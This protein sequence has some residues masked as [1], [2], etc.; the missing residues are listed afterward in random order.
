MAEGGLDLDMDPLGEGAEDINH[1]LT[2]DDIDELSPQEKETKENWWGRTKERLRRLGI[3]KNR[4]YELLTNPSESREIRGE[5]LIEE[6]QLIDLSKK[7]EDKLKIGKRKISTAAKRIRKFYPFWDPKLSS[8]LFTVDDFNITEVKLKGKKTIY[9]LYEDG[10]WSGK[11]PDAII[12][13][14]GRSDKVIDEYNNVKTKIDE[15]FPDNKIIFKDGFDL[16]YNLG[17]IEVTHKDKGYWY[18]LYNKNGEING[19]LPNIIKNALGHE[20]VLK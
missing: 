9:Y 8:F 18:N 13:S 3:S 15:L 17:K 10:S 7:S 14:L 1:D 20:T 5:K 11:I 4:G 6:I 19:N 2:T 16:R 12:N